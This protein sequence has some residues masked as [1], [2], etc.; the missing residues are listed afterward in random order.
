MIDEA[1]AGAALAAAQPSVPPAPGP[2]LQIPPITPDFNAPGVQGMS[3]FVNSLAAWGL[4]LAVAAIIIGVIL[5]AIGPRLKFQQASSLGMGGI[6]GGAA[7]GGVIAMATPA[8]QT[9]Y[10]WFGG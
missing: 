9:T 10:G 6:L 4:I 5:V 2:G 8:V 7:V 3:S 1:Q